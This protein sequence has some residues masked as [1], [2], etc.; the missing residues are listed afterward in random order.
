MHFPLC[1]LA[2]GPLLDEASKE[3]AG[4]L[5]LLKC[6]SRTRLMSALLGLLPGLVEWA[7]ARRILKMC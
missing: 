6:V 3:R 4:I 1:R 7:V 5:H 2:E